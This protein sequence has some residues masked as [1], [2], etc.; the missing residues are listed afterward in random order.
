MQTSILTEKHS[1]G[2]QLKNV[3]RHCNNRRRDCNLSAEVPRIPR[4]AC[5]YFPI[6]ES[7]ASKRSHYQGDQWM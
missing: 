4:N 7:I 2:N 1:S 3:P 6:L 5:K